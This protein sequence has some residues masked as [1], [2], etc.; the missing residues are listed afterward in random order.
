MARQVGLRPARPGERPCTSPKAL[1]LGRPMLGSKA[2]AV[3]EAAGPEP[4]QAGHQPEASGLRP[5]QASARPGGLWRA[6]ATPEEQRPATTTVWRR[7]R[8]RGG[9]PGMRV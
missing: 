8:A 4:A 1:A 6:S 9:L 7:H 2:G 3:A 5:A